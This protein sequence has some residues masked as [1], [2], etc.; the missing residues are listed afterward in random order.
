MH[1]QFFNGIFLYLIFGVFVGRTAG[2]VQPV[3]CPP[4]WPESQPVTEPIAGF[5]GFWISQQH[6]RSLA[7]GRRIVMERE[8]HRLVFERL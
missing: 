6:A 2:T 5:N 1:R 3:G 7:S 8:S 4:C